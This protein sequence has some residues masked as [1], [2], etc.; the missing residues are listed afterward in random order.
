MRP[1]YSYFSIFI[2]WIHFK[3]VYSFIVSEI[4]GVRRRFEVSSSSIIIQQYSLIW[5]FKNY[6]HLK[7][8]VDSWPLNNNEMSQDFYMENEDCIIVDEKDAIVGR[9]SKRQVHIFD[10]KQ[11]I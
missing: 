4:S 3:N 8:L 1:I 11:V 10:T 9:A 6:R 5:T 7:I 2:L